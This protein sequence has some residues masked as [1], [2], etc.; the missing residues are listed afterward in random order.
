MVARRLFL[1]LLAI[2]APASANVISLDG[3]NFDKE[4][5]QAGGCFVKFYVSLCASN[6][7]DSVL[8]FSML[9]L[10]CRT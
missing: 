4:A 9:I 8:P 1:W 7:A 2:A 10:H 6:R 5:R 3:D